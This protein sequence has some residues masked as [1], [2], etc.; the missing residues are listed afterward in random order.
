MGKNINYKT[1]KGIMEIHFY[2][3]RNC[4]LKKPNFEFDVNEHDDKYL[5]KCCKKCRNVK[6]LYKKDVV[7]LVK[8]KKNNKII[9]DYVML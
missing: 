4:K 2:K 7:Y 8:F 3:C 1:E 5:N 6:I 9:E